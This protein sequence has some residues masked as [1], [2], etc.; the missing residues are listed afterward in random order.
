MTFVV[1]KPGGRWEIRESVATEAGPRAHTLATFAVLTS[2][3]LE[4]ARQR[5][6]TAF[7]ETRVLSGASRAGAPVQLRRADQLAREL[8]RE[9]AEGNRPSVA[10]TAELQAALPSRS[11][12]PEAATWVGASLED[13][14][15]TVAQLLEMANAFPGEWKRGPLAMP[16]LRGR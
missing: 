11:H 12:R 2:E 5:A 1:A 16:P 6:K 4:R 8:L 15:R 9:I 14:G 10:L 13:R 3:T 7:D